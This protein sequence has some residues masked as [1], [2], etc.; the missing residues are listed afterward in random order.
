MRSKLE[1]VRENVGE[2]NV[3]ALVDFTK[4]MAR[5]VMIAKQFES[6]EKTNRRMTTKFPLL[7]VFPP[8]V[9]VVAG[10]QVTVVMF[11]SHVFV[12]L[13]VVEKMIVAEFAQRMAAH[14]FV[15][16]VAVAKMLNEFGARVILPFVRKQ[17][18]MFDAQ[19]A[20]ESSMLFLNMMT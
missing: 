9:S 11:L 17:I 7:D 2:L 8:V 14:R 20:V 6:A 4:V 10:A 19:I 5:T 18:Q 13:I 1:F 16:F 3:S 15:V 12:E